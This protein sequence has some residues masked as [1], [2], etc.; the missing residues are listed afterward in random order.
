MSDSPTIAASRSAVA[1]PIW[2][3]PPYRVH[4]PSCTTM[5]LWSTRDG[6]VHTENPTPSAATPSGTATKSMIA[7]RRV[8]RTPTRRIA[9]ASARKAMGVA[10]SRTNTSSSMAGPGPASLASGLSR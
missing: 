9:Y 4:D 1:N 5:T 2:S 7:S 8:N 6:S 10:A 3:I